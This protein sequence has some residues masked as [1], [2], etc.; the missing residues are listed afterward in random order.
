MSEP[1]H[2]TRI[3][4]LVRRCL[5][6]P[7]AEREA[8][9]ERVAGHDESVQSELFE[10]VA[11]VVAPQ[12]ESQSKPLEQPSDSKRP[13]P[14]QI[15]RFR[16]RRELGRG[17]MGVVYL[18]E[19][20]KPLRRNVALKLMRPAVSD[21]PHLFARFEAERQALALM[22]HPAIARVF[23]A[24]VTPDGKPW[25]AMEYIE[26]AKTLLEYVRGRNA[27]ERVRLEIFATICEAV[28]HGHQKGV[29]HRDLK[30]SN[31]LVDRE[32]QP[33]VIDFGV[34][35]LADV[36]STVSTPNTMSGQLLG[37]P[38]YMAPEQC[39]ADARATDVRSDVY[40]LGVILYELMTDHL[41]YEVRG[42]PLF[43]LL[44]AIRDDAPTSP[45]KYGRDLHPDLNTVLQKALEK[46]PDRRYPSAHEFAADVRR[47]LANEPVTARRPSAIY[48]LQTFARRHRAFASSVIAVVIIAVAGAII[49]LRF[50]IEA[51]QLRREESLRNEE[52]RRALYSQQIG[53]AAASLLDGDAG[54]ADRVLDETAAELRGF[55]YE[56]L[57]A[58]ADQ[59]LFA[60]RAVESQPIALRHLGARIV[61]VDMKGNVGVHDSGT[62][63]A[64]R[65]IVA[66]GFACQHGAISENGASLVAVC[67]DGLVRRFDIATGSITWESEVLASAPHRLAWNESGGEIAVCLSLDNRVTLLDAASGRVLDRVGIIARPACDAVWSPSGDRLIVR[68][69]DEEYDVFL[70][71]G[72]G[73]YETDPVNHPVRSTTYRS[74]AFVFARDGSSVAFSS[75]GSYL[76]IGAGGALDVIDLKTGVFQVRSGGTENALKSTC[77]AWLGNFVLY[78]T[79]VG[80]NVL[81]G[82]DGSME[83]TLCG[84]DSGA[85]TFLSAAP[86]ASS[87]ASV[88]GAGILRV[89]A[90][91]ANLTIAPGLA[92]FETIR[93]APSGNRAFAGIW[94]GLTCYDLETGAPLYYAELPLYVVS[95]LALN[96]SESKLALTDERG[97]DLVI[98][99]AET[100]TIEAARRVSLPAAIRTLQFID[101]KD[102]LAGLDDGSLASIDSRTFATQIVSPVAES[103]VIA[104]EVTPDHV[105]AVV[106]R[107]TLSNPANTLGDHV[108]LIDL[109]QRDEVWRFESVRETKLRGL[110]LSSDGSR[111]ALI[112]TECGVTILDR[113]TGAVL[114]S[115]TLAPEQWTSVAFAPD[116]KRLAVFSSTSQLW[117]LDPETLRTV[118]RLSTSSLPLNDLR[119]ARDG[120]KLF[121]W[122]ILELTAFET[123]LS[124]E[125]RLVRGRT[126]RVEHAVDELLRKYRFIGE[127]EP[128]LDAL[129]LAGS[130]G[131]ALKRR[132][133][134]GFSLNAQA[135][136][137]VQLFGLPRSEY[138]L[139]RRLATRALAKRPDY[140]MIV[141]TLAIAELHLE[142]YEAALRLFE[143]SDAANRGVD[144]SMRP[145]RSGSNVADLAGIAICKYEL[146]DLSGAKEWLGKAVVVG[147]TSKEDST[148]RRLL[149][150]AESRIGSN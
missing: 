125:M 57:R 52:L 111:V 3:E 85:I 93:F 43:E 143:R 33:K 116:G 59:S 16:I 146:G 17:G 30:P 99:R 14:P 118:A 97:E 31:I 139:A 82:F 41:P 114:R 40:S 145:H 47:Y 78:S 13:P 49:S 102:L 50:A 42:R 89:F 62:G 51:S 67:S 103:R 86:D 122:N 142:N 108:A 147:G 80:I 56:F 119:F 21:D 6:L 107:G 100:G 127:A 69:L 54:N 48:Q 53:L 126:E 134:S 137:R 115:T 131:Q 138:E 106:M 91:G 8:F 34:A 60:V 2:N 141:N 144:G 87:F 130:I 129:T 79:G 46:D 15:P 90:A 66:L 84:H 24:G 36:S 11:A 73:H 88:D 98:A 38:E 72:P 76:A 5:D 149:R 37:T 133:E 113:K 63:T 45:S 128:A 104:T 70:R 95:A 12:Y 110:A 68:H 150:E 123:R 39:A 25:F 10:R 120:A 96:V 9:I 61:T 26:G 117:L 20:M 124:P 112:D 140:S 1:T 92:K 135:W 101:E 28:H 35:R 94:G 105:F 55:E 18:A 136:E 58:G 74:G 32:G 148:G 29:L 4:H 44:R 23:D 109:S 81:S 77:I 27:T 121:G 64:L 132:P 71:R 19:Q 75:D 22:N 65:P 83:R 7:P